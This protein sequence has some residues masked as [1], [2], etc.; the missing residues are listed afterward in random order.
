ML[1]VGDS[2]GLGPLLLDDRSQAIDADDDPNDH[3][4]AAGW[5]AIVQQ[6]TAFSLHGLRIPA[7]EGVGKQAT[8]G[9]LFPL[10]WLKLVARLGV[11]AGKRARPRAHHEWRQRAGHD[12]RAYVV[13]TRVWHFTWGVRTGELSFAASVD[14]TALVRFKKR[15][16]HLILIIAIWV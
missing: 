14:I 4:A 15:N 7:T 5:D 13:T 2:V 9:L 10:Q 16:T 6:A 3:E 11:C 8:R 12:A 1:D